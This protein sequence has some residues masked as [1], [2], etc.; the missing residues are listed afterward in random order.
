MQ[1]TSKWQTHLPYLN[2]LTLRVHNSLLGSPASYAHVL[3]PMERV[4]GHFL[5]GPRSH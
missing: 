1:Q 4:L 2:L 3:S 5:V